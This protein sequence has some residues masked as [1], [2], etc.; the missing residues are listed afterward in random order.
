MTRI[1]ILLASLLVVGPA[2]AYVHKPTGEMSCS[3]DD[4]TFKVMV[5]QSGAV[6]GRLNSGELFFARGINWADNNDPSL[7][8]NN[9]IYMKIEFPIGLDGSIINCSPKR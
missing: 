1:L 6:E 9:D 2:Y 7:A 8:G 5:A 3:V 4:Q